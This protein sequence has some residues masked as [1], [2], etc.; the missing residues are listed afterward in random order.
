MGKIR[1]FEIALI[2]IF[3]IAGIAGIAFLANMK[4]DNNEEVKVYGDSVEM[5]GTLESSAVSS[6]L[7]SVGENDEEFSKVVQYR[8]FDERSFENEIVNAIADGNPP[9]LIL[10]PHDLIVTFRTKLFAVPFETIPQS[11]FRTDYIDGAQV[12]MLSDGIYGVPLAVDPLVLYY[13]RDL[14]ANEGIASPPKTWETLLND[15]VPRLTKTDNRRNLI[16]SAIGMGEYMNVRNAKEIL[17]LLLIQAGATIVEEQSGRYMVT[18]ET[19]RTEGPPPAQSALNFYTQ[20]ASPSSNAFTWSRSQQFD[21]NAFIAGKLA[22]YI[23]F[24]SE[25]KAI[26]D[27][28][29]NLNIDIVRVPQ[30]E[31]ATALRNY[32]TF[33]GLAIPKTSNNVVGA[34]TAAMRIAA[35]ENAATVARLLK[36]TPVLRSLYGQ[37]NDNLYGK[38]FEESALICRGWL[39]PAPKETKGVFKKMVEEVTFGRGDAVSAISEATVS[40]DELF[41]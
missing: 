32:G 9:D 35:P 16:Q 31:G 11:T 4:A 21:R 5:W 12:F 23:G 8:Q 25:Q 22:M 15:S 7:L 19:K 34:Y 13:N 26:E 28:N 2:G 10:M 20:F 27:G 30:A 36:V 37:A 33:Y 41:K 3:A 24:Q 14:F 1:P 40:L 6:A 18:L 17:S 38:I 39:D 29:P